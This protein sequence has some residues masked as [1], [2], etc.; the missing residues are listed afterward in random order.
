MHSDRVNIPP[1]PFMKG[2]ILTFLRNIVLQYFC[3]YVFLEY[4]V[5][6][7]TF[8]NLFIFQLTDDVARKKTEY[9]K[10]LEL[11][12]LMR[13]RFEEHYVKCK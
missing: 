4:V 9:Q 7:I 1:P 11:Y 5:V 2:S 3:Q 12:K 13:S 6:G 10:Y 8:F